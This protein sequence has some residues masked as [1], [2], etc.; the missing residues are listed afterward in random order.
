MSGGALFLDDNE[1][2][3]LTG[4]KLKSMQIAWLRQAGVPFRVSAT[5]HPVVVRS[6]IEGRASEPVPVKQAWTPRVL[7]TR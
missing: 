3:Q 1:L 2:I 4:R 7:A 6:V 5:G